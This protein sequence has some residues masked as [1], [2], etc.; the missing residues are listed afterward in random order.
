[1][2]GGYAGGIGLIDLVTGRIKEERDDEKLVRDSGGYFGSRLKSAG[3]D[4]IVVFGIASTPKYILVAENRTELRDASHI[5]GKDTVE[6]KDILKKELGISKAE[7]ASPGFRKPIS[8]EW[9]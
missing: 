2:T 8:H 1:M 9:D 3:W 4:A 5:L 7:L 6:T